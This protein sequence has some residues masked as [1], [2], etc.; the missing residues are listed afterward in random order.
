M[1]GGLGKTW[2]NVLASDF[3]SVLFIILFSK[4]MHAVRVQWADAVAGKVRAMWA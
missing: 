4:R 1:E 2:N 3:V